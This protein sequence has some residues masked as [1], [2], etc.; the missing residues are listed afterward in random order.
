[1]IALVIASLPTIGFGFKRDKFGR[2]INLIALHTKTPYRMPTGIGYL[3]SA[4]ICF[5]KKKNRKVN[6]IAIKK[7]ISSPQTAS[8]VGS[9]K[10]LGSNAPLPTPFKTCKGAVSLLIYACIQAAVIS[11]APAIKPAFNALA[12][13]DLF[14][15]KFWFRAVTTNI[16]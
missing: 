14:I 4:G 15:K 10:V 11:S 3:T 16:V 2:I 12:K 13:K 1:M 5:A 6:E 8:R 7:W 9:G